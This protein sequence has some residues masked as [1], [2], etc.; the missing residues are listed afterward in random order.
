MRAWRLFWL[1]DSLKKPP[2]SGRTRQQLS[3]RFTHTK[4][5]RCPHC[6]SEDHTATMCQFNSNPPDYGL[7][8]RPAAITIAKHTD[9]ASVV[10][11]RG[12]HSTAG[13]VLELQ[14]RPLLL[15][16]LPVHALLLG[17]PRSLPCNS[18]P[19][20]LS[21]PGQTHNGLR[22][23]SRPANHSLPLPLHAKLTM[24]EQGSQARETI[25][26]S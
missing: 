26:Q 16:P 4:G 13:G 19:T 2:N 5:P 1:R 6:L 22:V 9:A 15:V 11:F 20:E 10:Q 25:G 7:V 8:P 18:L 3:R 24:D 21:K 14:L 17:V 23:W 12:Q